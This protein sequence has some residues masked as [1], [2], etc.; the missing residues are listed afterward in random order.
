M[1]DISLMLAVGRRRSQR[2]DRD[3][4]PQP[5]VGAFLIAPLAHR[6]DHLSCC[7]HGVV[8]ILCDQEM[9]GTVDIVIGNGHRET[10]PGMGVSHTHT[11]YRRP[12]HDAMAWGFPLRPRQ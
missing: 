5:C 10:V 11:A 7:R 4:D 6:L 3:D 8:A 12:G 1:L 9:G 2:A